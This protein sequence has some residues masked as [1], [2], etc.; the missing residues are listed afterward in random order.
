MK[1]IVHSSPPRPTATS[2]RRYVGALPA[3][4]EPLL[5]DEQA[6]QAAR[7]VLERSDPSWEQRFIAQ[8]ETILK[9]VV[10]HLDH[11]QISGRYAITEHELRSIVARAVS[12]T[13]GQFAIAI[14]QALAEV[15]LATS[16]TA[17]DNPAEGYQQ[18]EPQPEF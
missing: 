18:P 11:D 4:T 6:A 13:G 5:L 2:I 1:N 16:F 7:S 9:E 3:V 15:P 17:E 12:R 10:P 14:G 8:I